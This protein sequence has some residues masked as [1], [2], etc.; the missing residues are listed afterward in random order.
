[1]KTSWD[2]S[3]N[4]GLLPVS[5]RLTFTAADVPCWRAAE[6]AAPRAVWPITGQDL[7]LGWNSLQASGGEVVADALRSN[8]SLLHLD[9]AN[10]GLTDSGGSH[11]ALAL[12]GNVGLKVRTAAVSA[13]LPL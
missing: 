13:P 6:H 10:N 3:S 5:L 12:Q 11:F 1:M 8:A 4:K 9:V 7:R 2:G